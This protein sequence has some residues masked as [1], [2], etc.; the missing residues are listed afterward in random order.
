[1]E[2]LGIRKLSA[3]DVGA[4]NTLARAGQRNLHEDELARFL[5]LEGAH[6]F[7]LFE[8]ERL[9]GMV[10]LMRYFDRGWLGPIVM[11]AGPDA[12]GLSMALAQHALTA[13][14]RAGVE[15]VETEATPE[16]VALLEPLGFARVRRTL[17][18][19]RAPG[20]ARGSGLTVPLERRHLLDLGEIES[21][22]V[23]FGRKEYLWELARGFPEGARA[24]E[25]DDEL[26]GY[27]LLRR[28][29]RGYML[30]PLVTREQTAEAADAL[31]A[32]AVSAVATWPI[33]ALSP[34]GGPLLPSLARM[35]FD[36]LSSLVRM[37]AGPAAAGTGGAST[38]WLLGGR[39]TG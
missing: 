25:R 35:G 19:E 30:G 1:M 14:Q 7:G 6:A 37:R 22:A 11:A 31:L 21:D 2:R 18:L 24:F 4:M 20:A 28:S 17:V 36:E 26:R 16:E 38:E 13:L 33:T 29:R 34:E 12:V 10:T 27:A 32:D 9:V 8:E 23:G 5:A 39:L 3:Q 15:T